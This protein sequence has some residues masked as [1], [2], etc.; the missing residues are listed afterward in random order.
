[1]GVVV[2]WAGEGGA[3]CVLLSAAACACSRTFRAATFEAAN[4]LGLQ[5]GL[6][7]ELDALVWVSCVCVSVVKIAMS[8]SCAQHMALNCDDITDSIVS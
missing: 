2:I 8:R 7:L 4:D 6:R 1:M 3:V 5:N